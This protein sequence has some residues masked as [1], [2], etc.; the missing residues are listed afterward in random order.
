MM[1]RMDVPCSEF[2]STYL[3]AAHRLDLFDCGVESL[4]RWLHDH[5]LRSQHSGHARTRVWLDAGDRVVAYYAIAPT[6]IEREGL[7]RSVTAGYSGEAPAFLLARLALDISL[8]G[9]GHGAQL[10]LDALDQLT[11]ALTQFGGVGV[12]VDAI[13]DNAVRFYEHFDFRRIGDTRRL[14]LKAATLGI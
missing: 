12:V 10:L 11:D 1:T 8:R 9:H 14:V 13:D 2:T 6:R 7:P 4:N 3:A 5:A